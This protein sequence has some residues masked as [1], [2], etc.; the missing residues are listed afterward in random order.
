M[1][2]K[3]TET[4]VTIHKIRKKGI[5]RGVRNVMTDSVYK[6]LAKS[7]DKE[8]AQQNMALTEHTFPSKTSSSK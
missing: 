7:S 8:H 6:P 5:K 1:G 2:K 3:Q 4:L